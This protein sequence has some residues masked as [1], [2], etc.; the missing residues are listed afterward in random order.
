MHSV[1]QYVA[2]ESH[3]LLACSVLQCVAVCRSVLQCVA[4]RDKR[5]VLS[6]YTEQ[7]GAICILIYLN[8]SHLKG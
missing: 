3:C 6:P 8:E 1:L 4:A 2:H 7:T 5:L